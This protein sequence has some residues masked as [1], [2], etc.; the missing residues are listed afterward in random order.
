MNKEFEDK[1][2]WVKAYG[3]RHEFNHRVEYGYKVKPHYNA[4][5]CYKCNKCGPLEPCQ[6]CGSTDLQLGVSR[7][8]Y[9]GIFCSHC[10]SGFTTYT[11]LE[12]GT[13]NPITH[14]TV[15]KKGSSETS[16]CFI[17][18]AVY[19][20]EYADDVLILKSFRDNFLYNR[21]AGELFIKLYYYLSPPL[22]DFIRK[23]KNLR[24]ILRVYFIHPLSNYL[25]N[26]FE[27]GRDSKQKD[28]S[29]TNS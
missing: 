26:K 29:E 9:I 4:I 3:G 12:C 14:E 18:T 23:R 11:C 20:S 13:K 22:A 2:Y 21:K 28:K 19:G 6:N 5:R 1:E 15:L 27:L 24:Y 7:D 17:A 10:H 8:G 25:G 16:G